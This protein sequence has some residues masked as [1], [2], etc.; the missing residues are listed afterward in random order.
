[1]S[2]HGHKKSKALKGLTINNTRQT[3]AKILKISRHQISREQQPL[4]SLVTEGRSDDEDS[5]IKILAL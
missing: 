2:G 3:R 1:V 5:S 4:P